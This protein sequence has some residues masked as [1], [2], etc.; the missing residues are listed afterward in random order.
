MA[1]GDLEWEAFAAAIADIA[2]V[3]A[4]LIRRDTRI[5]EDLALDSLALANLATALVV[6]FGMV[7]VSRELETRTW[8]S[9]SVG[10]L[11]DEYR[12]GPDLPVSREKFRFTRP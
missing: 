3:D 4:E 10:R 12:S 7:R 6:D 2:R 11:Y 8:E 9:V 1:S 5:L